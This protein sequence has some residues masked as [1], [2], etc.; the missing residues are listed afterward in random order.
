MK[1]KP[2]IITVMSAFLA[3]SLAACGEKSTTEVT[4]VPTTKMN[5][6]LEKADFSEM[7]ITLSDEGYPIPTDEAFIGVWSASTEDASAFYSIVIGTN[8]E[9]EKAPY[10]ITITGYEGENLEISYNW[11]MNARADA[12]NPN[13]LVYSEA[14]KTTSPPVTDEDLEARSELSEAELSELPEREPDYTDGSGSF[15]IQEDSLIWTDNKEKTAWDLFFTK[16]EEDS[17]ASDD[18]AASTETAAPASAETDVSS[19]KPPITNDNGNRLIADEDIIQ[20]KDATWDYDESDYPDWEDD[21]EIEGE[22][23]TE[24]ETETE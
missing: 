4:S 10:E 5:A 13:L 6:L 2:L 1:R 3:L 12:T 16:V 11:K 8:M 24:A 17:S 21:E 18:M 15:L 7:D 22:V 19:D 23:D 14:V 9:N 20:E